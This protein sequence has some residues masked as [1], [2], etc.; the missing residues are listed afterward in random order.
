MRVVALLVLGALG[1]SCVTP[2]QPSR[3]SAR[4]ETAPRGS[5]SVA[6]YAITVPPGCEL[7]ESSDR[8]GIITCPRAKLDWL[9]DT[10]AD[11]DARVADIE[12]AGATVME[13]F[14]TSC[15]VGEIEGQGEIVVVDAEG[16]RVPVFLC[17]VPTGRAFTMVRCMGYDARVRPTADPPVPPPCD[18]V[19]P[20]QPILTAPPVVR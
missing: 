5:L 14:A 15:Q 18:Q 3:D 20:W 4:V 2:A 1:P 9:N 13:R 12:Q 8:G 17:A 16:V 19:L 11:L 7:T 10:G 6:G